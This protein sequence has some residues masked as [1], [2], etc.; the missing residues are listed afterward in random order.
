MAS[1]PANQRC[2]SDS[3]KELVKLR[4]FVQERCCAF[5]EIPLAVGRTRVVAKDYKGNVWCH[6]VNRTQHL[7]AGTAELS[8]RRSRPQSGA[9]LLSCSDGISSSAVSA[10]EAPQTSQNMKKAAV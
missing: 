2:L 9:C 10:L 3:A 4:A 1:V 5:V 7:Q 8:W 6:R